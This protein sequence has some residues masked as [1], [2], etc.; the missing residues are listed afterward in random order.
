MAYSTNGPYG[1]G[2]KPPQP[3]GMGK[4]YGENKPTLSPQGGASEGAPYPGEIASKTDTDPKS[5]YYGKTIYTYDVATGAIVKDYRPLW[6]KVM[7]VSQA[8]DFNTFT[9]SQGLN[10]TRDITQTS[11]Y[12]GITSLISQLQNPNLPAQD[13]QAAIDTL[14][15]ERGYAT[16][17]EYNTAMNQRATELNQ[18][19]S[20][21]QG[22][23]EEEKLAFQRVAAGQQ[24]DLEATQ[25][26]QLDS[27][28]S[29]QTGNSTARALMQANENI[30][31]IRDAQLQS[32]VSLMNMD[33]AR[34]LDEFDRKA[35]LYKDAMDRG[36]ITI[37][38]F[39]DAYK[40]NRL[41]ALQGFAS[42]VSTIMSQNQQ[43]LNM[44]TSDLDKVRTNAQIV[45]QS[46]STELGIDEAAQQQIK[47]AFDKYAAEEG[48]KEAQA[49]R[50]QAQNQGFWS[51]I[52]GLLTAIGLIFF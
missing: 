1:G 11:P 35:Q 2:Y 4:P 18:G 46:V 44:Y 19:V 17:E 8:P 21:Q 13:R 48:L 29:G 27:I 15:K 42:Q 40:N 30:K 43:Y 32:T 7:S 23:T 36:E 31:T 50:Q 28:L 3:P 10:F 49:Q 14:A 25:R 5:K 52:G 20:G 45:Y 26:R 41:S 37:Q 6:D 12:Q 38:N 24:Q 9:Q 39:M 47:D 51:V 22:M 33:Y 16:G 34:K